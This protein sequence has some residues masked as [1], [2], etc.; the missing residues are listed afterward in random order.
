MEI[1]KDY[2]IEMLEGYNTAYTF[3]SL[4][5]NGLNT[6]HLADI[7]NK[8]NE[9]I[10]LL[11]F[12]GGTLSFDYDISSD[13]YG[14]TGKNKHSV[15][16]N[17]KNFI[18]NYIDLVQQLKF[19]PRTVYCLNLHPFFK[20]KN[21][22]KWE[23]CLLP[24]KVLKEKLGEDNIYCVELGNEIFMHFAKKTGFYIEIC[25][26]LIPRIKEILPNVIISVPTE[27]CNSN[28]G[29]DWNK[30][31]SKIKDI[32]AINPHFYIND[33]NLIDREFIAK[34]SILDM[35]TF[36]GLTNHLKVICTEYN[37]KFQEGSTKLFTREIQNEI[38]SKMLFKAKE[39]NFDS[40]LY[41][42]LLQEDKYK[43]SKYSIR[44][45]Q[46]NLR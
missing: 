39:L 15:I 1:P 9:Q 19:K 3:S 32:S 29:N 10:D 16:R 12:P 38:V 20:D 37:Y 25:N 31:V 46:I 43:Y 17:P 41:H 6:L 45:K 4:F 34:T 28:R 24:L 14:E 27:G 42:S 33:L 40:M 23:N 36:R 35:G 26:F 5:D 30:R 11:R 2:R 18:Y 7:I 8:N 13:G 22:N 44:N 21:L